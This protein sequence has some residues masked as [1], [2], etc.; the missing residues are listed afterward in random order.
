MNTKETMIV[1][2]SK[3][4]GIVYDDEAVSVIVPG[5]EGV[6]TILPQHEAFISP[7]GEGNIE[8]ET[9]EGKETIPIK[10]GVIEVS[11]NQVSI[12]I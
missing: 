3:V 6:L 5:I 4:T 1:T 11:D 2:V 12:L 8:I 10:K 7:L 9:T